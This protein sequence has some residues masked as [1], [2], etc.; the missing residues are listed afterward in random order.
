MQGFRT[1][2]RK[3][4]FYMWWRV[5]AARR[6]VELTGC[7]PYH[8]IQLANKTMR[9]TQP[10][11]WVPACPIGYMEQLCKNRTIEELLK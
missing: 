2:F 8:A 5:K 3:W 7:K 10:W 6:V 4:L 9:E 1:K 11:I